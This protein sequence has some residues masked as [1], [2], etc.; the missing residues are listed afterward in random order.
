MERGGGGRVAALGGARVLPGGRRAAAVCAGAGQGHL[1]DGPRGV[2]GARPR[3]H[4]R[5]PVGAPRDIAER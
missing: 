5:Y 3:L 4:G 2:R 1:R